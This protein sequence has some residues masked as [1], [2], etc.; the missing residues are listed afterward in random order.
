MS[1][2]S[3]GGGAAYPYRQLKGCQ[4]AIP[5]YRG[6]RQEPGHNSHRP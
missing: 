6:F 4:Q 5:L 3:L 1:H 2:L